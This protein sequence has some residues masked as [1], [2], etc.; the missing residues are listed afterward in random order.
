MKKI[1]LLLKINI[2]YNRDILNILNQ[3]C[4]YLFNLRLNTQKCGCN[5]VVFPLVPTEGEV[6][7]SFLL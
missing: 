1:V 3:E 2:I 6:T 5:F 7:K 4:S